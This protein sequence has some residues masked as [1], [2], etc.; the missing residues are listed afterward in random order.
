MHIPDG[1]LDAKTCVVSGLLAAGGLGYALHHVRRTLPGRKVPLLGL[2]AAFVFAAQMINFP[3][4][5]GTSGHLLG[6]T[7]VAALLGP[8]AAVVV[9]SA[10]LIVQCLAFADG[11]ITAL[12]ANIFNMGIVGGALA[13]VIYSVLTRASQDLRWRVFAAILAAWVSVFLAAV[14]ASGEL[15]CSG[16]VSWGTAFPAMASVHALIGIGEGIITATVLAAIASVRR[17]LVVPAENGG[18]R[19]SL[20]PVIILGV[21]AA[22]G[23]ALFVSP[24]ASP[25]PDGLERVAARLGF[26]EQAS[27]LPLMPAPAGDYKMPGL[28]TGAVATSVAGGVGTLVVLGGAWLLARALVPRKKAAAASET[29]ST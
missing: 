23:I 18:P 20:K 1:F 9:L 13:G 14:A 28:G 8:S 25:Y 24:F 2:A 21:L 5:G 11:G 6:G 4:M 26:E 22:V 29:T 12:G 27:K 17:E 7:L 15:A 16:T 19:L 10:V 3:V